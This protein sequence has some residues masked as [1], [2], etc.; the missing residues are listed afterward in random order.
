MDL[1]S[2]NDTR[3]LSQSDFRQWGKSCFKMNSKGFIYRFCP[4]QI[5]IDRTTPCDR[6]HDTYQRIY[7]ALKSKCNG[8][9]VHVDH[10]ID[11]TPYT[12]G[13]IVPH[14]AIDRQAWCDRSP[15]MVRSI[16]RL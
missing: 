6:S 5:A 15:S 9:I 3:K 8:H 4:E 13:Y 2:L 12:N 14:G 1:G 7:S 11:R 16:A 10:A